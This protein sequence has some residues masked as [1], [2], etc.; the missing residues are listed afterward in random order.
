M[1]FMKLLRGCFKNTVFISP[2]EAVRKLPTMSLVTKHTTSVLSGD[3]TL[4]IKGNQGLK[5]KKS[6]L[7]LDLV[8]VRIMIMTYLIIGITCLYYN[9]F[10]CMNGIR[11]KEVSS[12]PFVKE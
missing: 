3:N 12:D 7:K 4:I 5:K 11:S 8:N 10:I 2:H 9:M 6:I 1:K